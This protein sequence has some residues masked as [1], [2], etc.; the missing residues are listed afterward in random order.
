M[1]GDDTLDD[2]HPTRTS[3]LLVAVASVATA[4]ALVHSANVVGPA[5]VGAVGAITLAGVIWTSGW[6]RHE[7]AGTV[8]ASVLALPVGVGIVAATAGTVLILAGGLF[9]VP[10]AGDVPATVIRLSAR[11]M[12]VTGAVA[13]VFGATTATRGVVD[14]DAVEDAASTSF[15][16]AFLPFAFATL[17]AASGALRF[18][19]ANAQ[20]P[21][22]QSIVGDVIREFRRLLFEP[23]LVGPHLPTFVVMAGIALFATQRGL[24]ALPI[25]ELLTENGTEQ[26]WHGRIESGLRWLFWGALATLGLTPIAAVLHILLPP[27]QLQAALGPGPYDL[28]ATVTANPGLRT[29]CWWLI[30]GGFAVAGFVWLLRRFVQ[31]SA[32]RIGSVVA[33]FVGGLAITTLAFVVARDVLSTGLDWITEKLPGELGEMFATMAG[34]VVDV[35]G[36]ATIVLAATALV[37]LLT[38]FLVSVLYTVIKTGYVEERTAGVTIASLALFNTAAFAGVLDVSNTLVLAA[39]VAA[40]LVWDAGEFGVTL[41]EEIGRR[42][43]TRRAE[44]VHATGTL[45][46]GGFGAGIALLIGGRS[47]SAVDAGI[48]PVALGL[49]AVMA[50]LMLLVVALR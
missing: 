17:L 4:A 16:T 49:V 18:L 25:L 50:G 44:L 45:A 5:V 19:E 24:R 46:V 9:P 14:A 11:A 28:L 20:G 43:S 2:R 12:V 36:A 35:F 10:A 38:A 3:T 7:A 26:E 37:L 27:R 47:V 30:L 21:G 48:G 41:G 39:L 6:E 1:T 42:A 40:V 32:D 23:E 15:R 8:L 22:V 13:A 33:P 34:D 31:S 29:V